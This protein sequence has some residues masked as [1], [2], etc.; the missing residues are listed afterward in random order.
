MKRLCGGAWGEDDVESKFTELSGETSGQTR[1]LGALKGVGSRI[2]I[3]YKP[4]ASAPARAR[5]AWR[6]VKAASAK[7]LFR[8]VLALNVLPDDRERGTAAGDDAI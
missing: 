1:W 3:R 6:V 4:A 7:R 5:S 2:V 8:R